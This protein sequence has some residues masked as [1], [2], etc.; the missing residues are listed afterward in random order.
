MTESTNSERAA[1]RD[2]NRRVSGV[3]DPGKATNDAGQT[4]GG[5]AKSAAPPAPVVPSPR[6]VHY[7]FDP[8]ATN[9]FRD[10]PYRAT[11]AYGTWL[12]R[13]GAAPEERSKYYYASDDHRQICE[14]RTLDRIRGIYYAFQGDPILSRLF[15]LTFDFEVEVSDFLRAV[16]ESK[17]KATMLSAEDKNAEVSRVKVHL[18]VAP[19]K[20]ES[21]RATVATAADYDKRLGFWPISAFEAHVAEKDGGYTIIDQQDLVEQKH[22]VWKLGATL[23][24]IAGPSDCPQKL[25][26][27]YDLSSLDL[28][29]SVDS[30]TARRDRGEA[31]HTGGFTV[32][33]RGRADQIARDLALAEFQKP[34]LGLPGEVVALHAEELTIGR[35]VH[36]AAAAPGTP[37]KDLQWRSLMHRP[38]DFDFGHEDAAAERILRRLFPGRRTRNGVLDEVSFQVAARFIPTDP[39]KPEFEAVAEEAI[40]LWDGTPAGVLTD[41]G[42]VGKPM[43]SPL[44]FDR[45][46]RLPELGGVVEV[47]PPLRFGVPY[48]FLCVSAVLGGGSPAPTDDEL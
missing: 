39:A 44:P 17:A 4:A 25:P 1:T 16:G 10:K 41:S 36:V 2:A 21:K 14:G 5:K 15:C 32:L 35:R 8:I 9:P 23:S 13:R 34:R 48:A 45:R 40:F 29:R 46:L 42:L 7:K 3:L 33:D 26:P 37:L 31:Q 22:G 19:P 28:R 38:V 12:Q 43:P 18:A 20:F 24:P 30:K 11:H 27:R 47:P 6:D